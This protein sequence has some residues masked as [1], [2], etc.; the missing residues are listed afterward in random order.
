MSFPN[1]HALHHVTVTPNP[2]ELTILNP[3]LLWG[4]SACPSLS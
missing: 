1:Q 3:Q 4:E 2:A